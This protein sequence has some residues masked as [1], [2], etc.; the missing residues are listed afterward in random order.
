MVVLVLDTS[1]RKDE[2]NYLSVAHDVEISQL[3]G[4]LH[5]AISSDLDDNSRVHHFDNVIMKH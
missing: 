3:V 1:L 4:S 5:I 2:A